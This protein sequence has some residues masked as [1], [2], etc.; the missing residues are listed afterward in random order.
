LQVDLIE[1]GGQYTYADGNSMYLQSGGLFGPLVRELLHRWI[2]AINGYLGLL[3]SE[4]YGGHS[5]YLLI[6]AI[7]ITHVKDQ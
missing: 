1:P 3:E 5:I 7:V 2:P 4:S 6:L